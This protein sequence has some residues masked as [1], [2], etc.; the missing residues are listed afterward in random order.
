V[1][2]LQDK[3]WIEDD[4]KR[5]KLMPRTKTTEVEEEPAVMQAW[6]YF[7]RSKPNSMP[8][9]PFPIKQVYIHYDTNM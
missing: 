2:N 4:K 8:P 6:R 5:E 3:G 7:L 9:D 1:V